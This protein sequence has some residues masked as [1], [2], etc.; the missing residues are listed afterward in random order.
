LDASSRT[1]D[2]EQVELPQPAGAAG[3]TRE[4]GP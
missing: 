1:G 4:G 3:Q 2:E